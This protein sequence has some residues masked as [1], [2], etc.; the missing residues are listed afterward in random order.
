[1]CAESFKSEWDNDTESWMYHH[2]QQ[3]TLASDATNAMHEV[4]RLQAIPPPDLTVYEPSSAQYT[5][6]V[7]KEEDRQ[8]DLWRQQQIIE[9]VKKY[10]GMI[11]HQACHHGRL[12][13]IM[14]SRRPQASPTPMQAS[15][16]PPPPAA[17]GAAVQARSPSPPAPEVIPPQQAAVPMEEDDGEEYDDD[18]DDGVQIVLSN[19]PV[20]K[21]DEPMM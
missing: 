4:D 7:A 13:S 11:L 14:K 18:D 6:A 17:A 21:Q 15:N 8:T 5:A 9:H 3:I 16:F 1:M 2:C 19:Q 10:N 20:V 12:Y